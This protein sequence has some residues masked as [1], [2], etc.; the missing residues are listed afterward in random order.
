MAI[1]LDQV[2]SAVAHGRPGSIP[3]LFA[4][5]TEAD[6]REIRPRVLALRP[7]GPAWSTPLTVTE[8]FQLAR[9][10]VEG[11]KAAVAQRL[12]MQT[13]P[14]ADIVQVLLD[15][16]LPYLTDVVT[17]LLT[18]PRTGR[19]ESW[20]G[21][22]A[23][24]AAA[25]RLRTHLGVPRPNSETYLIRLLSGMRQPPI[26][27]IHQHRD[28]AP[29][30]RHLCESTDLDVLWLDS[31]DLEA[32]GAG[33]IGV[34]VAATREGILDRAQTIDSVL[35]AV[36]TATDVLQRLDWRA[37]L[38]QR[39]ALDPTEIA[40]RTESILALLSNRSAAVANFA[41]T[42]LARAEDAGRLEPGVRARIA[43]LL[44]DRGEVGRGKDALRLITQAVKAG[45]DPDE[46]A[47]I[48]ASAFSHPKRS[49][50]EA[51]IKT[52]RRL[53][54][55]VS[56]ATR[57]EIAE[58]VPDLDEPLR[59]TAA[60]LAPGEDTS[61]PDAPVVAELVP[62]PPMPPRVASLAEF[63][64]LATTRPFPD[65]HELERLVDGSCTFLPANAARVRALDPP[66][67]GFGVFSGW[68][69]RDLCE[70]WRR[71]RV[72][73]AA[74]APT[75]AY[76][77]NWAGFID[78]DRVVHDLYRASEVR[79]RFGAADLAQ[80]LLRWPLARFGD[81]VD[82]VAAVGTKDAVWL[83]GQLAQGPLPPVPVTLTMRRVSWGQRLPRPYAEC[84]WR[85]LARVGGKFAQWARSLPPIAER[86]RSGPALVLPTQRDA[87]ATFFA[88]EG[89]YDDPRLTPPLE[90]LAH[91]DGRAGA[92]VA[93]AIAYAAT[94]QGREIRAEAT[95]TLI[96]FATT[97]ALHPQTA[98]NTFSWLIAHP[99]AT[100]LN[101]WADVLTEV[102][103]S[104]RAGAGFTHWLLHALLT[105]ALNR[106]DSA[107]LIAR[108][109][110]ADL[111]RVAADAAFAVNAS[112]PIAGLDAIT[113]RGGGSKL[114][115]E[116]KRLQ[117]TT[118][119]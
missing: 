39:L 105:N 37:A 42:A 14:V 36:A 57:T 114:V 98:G 58:H 103:R 8:A 94:G 83:A 50:Q 56:A 25:E 85:P 5:A 107:E 30:L 64:E 88:N 18:T 69:R 2:A 49:V 63:L 21:T 34:I 22:D 90:I 116:A 71:A 28:V 100:K 78:P 112:A 87:G 66:R 91:Q 70:A 29:L 108:A 115:K 17:T 12:N 33:W 51:A 1:D 45:D 11:G 84:D 27:F 20:W 9:L 79:H 110:F 113:D 60:D 93:L 46:L 97:G 77:D 99:E 111:L 15:R 96:A 104:S 16:D 89:H 82:P 13:A 38:L 92:G 72:T 65:D 19:P 31:G 73:E 43:A 75:L 95:D 81:M 117:S 23:P 7:T 3:G 101:R 119:R 41:T 52:V 53:V 6:R 76:P 106:P 102:V 4:G 10:A 68:H 26:E 35:A 118:L 62:L 59:P 109:G 67:G 74:N 44:L 55:R 61:E 80:T 40:A 48:A 54:D 86:W 24:F 47:L 32:E